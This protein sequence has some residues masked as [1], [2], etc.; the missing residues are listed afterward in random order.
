[1]VSGVCG[2]AAVAGGGATVNL[3]HTSVPIEFSSQ[4]QSVQYVL[5]YLLQLLA[6]QRLLLVT[7]TERNP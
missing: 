7:E 6:R 3:V 2:G 5:L 4:I 1:M